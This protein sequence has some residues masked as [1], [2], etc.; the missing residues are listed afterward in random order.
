M[1]RLVCIAFS[2]AA[3]LL[4]AAAAARAAKPPEVDSSINPDGTG[5]LFATTNPGPW[6]WEACLAPGTGCHPFARG[7]IV[8]TADAPAG[9]IFRVTDGSGVVSEE[10]EWLGRLKAVAPPQVAGSLLANG[11][12][13]PVTG[14]WSGG[15][16]GEDSEMQL[17]A[18]TTEAGQGCISITAF[19]FVREGCASSDSFYLNPEFAGL[20]LR[21][22]D[23][24]SGGPH[25]ETPFAVFSPSGR[26]WGFE[27]VWERSRATSVAVVGQIAA[28]TTPSTGEC[29]PSPSPRAKILGPGVARVECPA[30]CE[31]TLV[32]SRGGRTERVSGMIREQSLLRPE[33]ALELKLPP[34]AI[35]RLGTG[36]VHLSV[37]I[38]GA[39]LTR[40]TLSL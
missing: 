21:V 14:L 6:R 34:S 36:R 12:V 35:K 5:Q 33:P 3:V 18:C 27:P 32:G 16:R 8:Q 15:W 39:P 10:R 17:S 26:N 37:D 30:G 19:H 28:S 20:Y 22:A 11:Y 38:D 4:V 2:F 29:G 13:S 25:A 1:K 23:R 40:R 7:R 24:Q 9:T 31:A